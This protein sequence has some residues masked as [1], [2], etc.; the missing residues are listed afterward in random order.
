[1]SGYQSLAMT[2]QDWQAI[3]RRGF[4]IAVDQPAALPRSGAQNVSSGRR[5]AQ[6]VTDAVAEYQ[7]VPDPKPHGCLARI[8]AKHKTTGCSILCR[9]DR[10][11]QEVRP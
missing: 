3:F 5:R 2:Q 6:N 11:K 8:A 7:A 1:M 9:I 4:W 10:M